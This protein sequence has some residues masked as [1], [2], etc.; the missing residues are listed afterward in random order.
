[1]DN[2]SLGSINSGNS[3]PGEQL[4]NFQGL[5]TTDLERLA[6]L[7]MLIVNP[8]SSSDFFQRYVQLRPKGQLTA[9][10]KCVC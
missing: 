5:C 4:L 2:T 8:F 1:M 7:R 3:W 9:C 6:Q 10:G